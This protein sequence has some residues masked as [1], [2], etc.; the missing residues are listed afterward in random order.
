MFE[1]TGKYFLLI[2]LIIVIVYITKKICLYFLFKRAKTAPYK[3][4]IPIY[5]TWV[6]VDLLNMKKK[7]FYLCLIPL[8]NLF[9][10]HKIYEELLVGFG[11]DKKEAIWYTLIPMYKFPE[12]VFKKPRFILNE[13][14]LTSAFM[15]SQKAL[16][17]KPKDE[18]PDKI[19]LVNLADKVDEFHEQQANPSSNVVIEPVKYEQMPG[20]NENVSSAWD[21]NPEPINDFHNNIES[22]PYNSQNVGDSV[23]TNKNLEPDKRQEKE[24]IAKKEE[25]KEEK[26]INPYND[27]RPQMCP[28]CGARLAPGATTCFLCG[29]KLK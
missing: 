24:Y 28:N 27:G 29:T 10:Y 21:N 22:S 3:A 15:E 13:Y 5:T 12:L 26:P 11:Q 2:F 17:E 8:V 14:D 23:F 16:F 18:L 1:V 7:I 9:Y 19:E 6:L 25:K 4:L 20:L